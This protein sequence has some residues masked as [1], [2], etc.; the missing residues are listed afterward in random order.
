M[1]GHHGDARVTVKNLEV[2]SVDPITNT[3]A[4]KG[5]VPGAR[6]GLILV[7]TRNETKTIWQA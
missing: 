5:A 6:G 4:I 2:V 1:G 7:Q 3:I